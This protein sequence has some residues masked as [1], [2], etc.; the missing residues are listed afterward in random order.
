MRRRSL[1]GFLAL[2]VVVTFMVTLGIIFAYTR[3]APT[4]TPRESPPLFVNITSTPNPNQTPAIQYIV[5]TATPGGA[6]PIALNLT[7]QGTNGALAAA[8][9]GTIP[10][11]DSSLIALT[12]S[13]TTDTNATDTGATALPTN[14]NGCPT[15][16]VKGGDVPGAIATNFNVTLADLYKANHLKI[17]PILQIGQVLIIPVNGCGLAT[18]TPTDT[19]TP[20]IEP[21]PPP[22]STPA[23]TAANAAIQIGQVIKPGDI[24]EEGVELDN[25]SN[26]VVELKG[27]TLSDGNGNVFTFPEYR[28]FPGGRVLISTRAGTATPRVLYWG[29]SQPLWGDASTVITLTDDKNT[30]QATF[31]VGNAPVGTA[32]ATGQASGG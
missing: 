25:N 16:T 17:D 4:P 1:L 31:A 12:L 28:M 32:S 8:A 29:R 15:Y 18:S 20:P 9:L 10:T 21:T 23:S 11:I 14:A 3:L 27:W 6:T 13:G 19:P 26:G 5:I 7:A 30:I 24:T 2:N 22:S